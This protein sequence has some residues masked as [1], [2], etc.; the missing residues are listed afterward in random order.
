MFFF[1]FSAIY[2]EP[3]KLENKC[4]YNS[5]MNLWKSCDAVNLTTNFRVGKSPWNE[6]LNRIRLGE[7]TKEDL[8]LLKSRYTS[9]FVNRENWDG[10]I[11]TFFSNKEVQ[12]HNIKVLNKMAGKLFTFEAEL[13][14]GKK[15]PITQH[16][17]I[18]TTNFMMK[19]EL[20]KAANV[21]LLH[22]IDI[23]DGLGR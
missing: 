15:P 21:M 6:T 12:K 20:K 23:S 16:G 14:K 18:G 4:L 1:L 8:E 3:S 10:A 22:N 9:N 11:H 17:T 5:D 13:P 7:Q 2:M 19:L